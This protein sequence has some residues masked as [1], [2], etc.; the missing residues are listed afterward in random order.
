MAYN[1]KINSRDKDTPGAFRED[2]ENKYTNSEGNPTK[3]KN[4]N[5]STTFQGK[6]SSVT[7][8]VMI[9]DGK[10][11]SGSITFSKNFKGGHSIGGGVTKAVNSPTNI[12]LH[13]NIKLSKKGPKF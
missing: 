13:A 11:T 3:K 8:S 6:K 5:L 12:N 10:P 9:K 2:Q 1:Q 7:P 4:I